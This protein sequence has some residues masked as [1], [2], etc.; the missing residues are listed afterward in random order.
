MHW[1]AFWAVVHHPLKN[2]LWY[3]FQVTGIFLFGMTAAFL[4]V[5]LRQPRPTLLALLRQPG[6]VAGLAMVLGLFWGTGF[7]IIL[8]PD[9]VDS[10]TAAPIA[11][12][13]TVVVGWVV[14]ALSRKWA[15]EPGWIDRLGRILGCAAIGTAILGLMIFRI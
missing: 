14:L 13:G 8:F 6:L 5:R 1:P 2:S 10:M 4:A 3:G 12:G 7:L 11:V 15:H 9:K